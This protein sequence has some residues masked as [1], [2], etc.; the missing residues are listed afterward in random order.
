MNQPATN[1]TSQAKPSALP[2]TWIAALFS[3]LSGMYGNKFSDMWRGI[4]PE[5]VK[6]TWAERLV[7]YPPEVLKYAL[8]EC[9]NYPNPPSLPQFVQ[10]CRA[11]MNRHVKPAALP[12][13]TLDKATA[14]ARLREICE[15]TGFPLK[16][17]Q[18]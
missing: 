12:P 15:K 18:Q 11:G 3:K 16:G 17:V 14:R 4:D 13:P 2:E 5:M 9:D 1:E 6:R 7:V 8:S 10:L